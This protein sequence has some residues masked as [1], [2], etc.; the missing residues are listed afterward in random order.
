MKHD[1]FD[2]YVDLIVKKFRTTKEELFQKNK[3]RDLVDA[4]QL[5]YYLCLRRNIS[6]RYIQEYMKENGYSVPHSTIIHG[7]NQAK[8]RMDQDYDYEPIV[9]SLE[10]EVTI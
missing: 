3:R 2:S 9:K 5:L 4:R 7:I 1:V 8:F 10:R 6:V